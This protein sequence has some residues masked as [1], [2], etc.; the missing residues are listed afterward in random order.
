MSDVVK[1]ADSGPDINW[2]PIGTRLRTCDSKDAGGYWDDSLHIKTTE[3]AYAS[4][5]PHYTED[6]LAKM[7]AN[8]TFNVS[9]FSHHSGNVEVLN[10]QHVIEGLL[11]KVAELHRL[12]VANERLA[13]SY[14]RQLEDIRSFVS[15]EDEWERVEVES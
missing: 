9:P 5:R 6:D 12:S 1:L 14:R 10:P 15:G 11:R 13:D 8:R 3:N 7:L 4:Y 2:L